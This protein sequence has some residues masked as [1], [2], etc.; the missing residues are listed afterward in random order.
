MGFHSIRKV[1]RKSNIPLAAD[2][3]MTILINTSKLLGS[4]YEGRGSP[5]LEKL[6]SIRDDIQVSRIACYANFK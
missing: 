6:S 5:A 2:L 3:S 1:I 4:Q